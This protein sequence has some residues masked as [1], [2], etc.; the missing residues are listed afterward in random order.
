MKLIRRFPIYHRN[1]RSKDRF[2]VFPRVN[3]GNRSFRHEQ[4]FISMLRMRGRFTLLRADSL[5]KADLFRGN[6]RPTFLPSRGMITRKG[7]EL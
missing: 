4:R 2:L 3:H 7:Q 6:L 5:Y 1:R